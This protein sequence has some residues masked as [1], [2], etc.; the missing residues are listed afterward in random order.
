MDR[1]KEF[2]SDTRNAIL[3]IT[4][5]LGFIGTLATGVFWIDDRYAK[6]EQVEELDK[7]VT[8]SELK[9]QLRLALEEYY[10]LKKQ[11]RKYP[12]DEDIQRELEEAKSVVDDLKEKIKNYK[13]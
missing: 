11:A 6:A 8:L 13:D 12:D 7:R 1:I 4:T 5:I 9:D 2:L 10:F 3:A